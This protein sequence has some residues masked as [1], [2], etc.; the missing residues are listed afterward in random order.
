MG[1]ALL[2]RLRILTKSRVVLDIRQ[3]LM[4][5]FKSQSDNPDMVEVFRKFN[6]GLMPLCEYHDVILC[7]DSPLRVAERELIVDGSGMTPSAAMDESRRARLAAAR[8]IP[9]Y[10]RGFARMVFEET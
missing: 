6:D 5:I 3:Y 8:D 7:G 9:A 1:E 10:Y 4:R 2:L